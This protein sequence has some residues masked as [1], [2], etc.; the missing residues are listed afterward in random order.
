MHSVVTSRFCFSLFVALA[1]CGWG[2]ESRAQSHATLP[3]E[4]KSLREILR[5]EQASPQTLATAR[6]TKPG[7]SKLDDPWVTLGRVLFF[8][9]RLSGTNAM[10]CATCHTPGLGWADGQPTPTRAP[11]LDRHTQSLWNVGAY[12]EL[13]WDGRASNLET[14]VD[15]PLESPDEMDGS[16]LKVLLIILRDDGVKQLV[17]DV[18]GM[19]LLQRAAAVLRKS[20]ESRSVYTGSTGRE[21]RRV[22]WQLGAIDRK[23][24]DAAY[25][26]VTRSL[27]EFQKTIVSGPAAFD[28]ATTDL[29]RVPDLAEEPM[30]RGAALFFG[31]AGCVSCHQGPYL[32][33]SRFHPA[34]PIS[35]GRD[36]GL[37]ATLRSGHQQDP[38][39]FVSSRDGRPRFTCVAK[40]VASRRHAMELLK[41]GKAKPAD[42]DGLFKTPSLRDVSTH[43]PY[44]HDGSAISLE[45]AVRSEAKRLSCNDVRK[46][47][48]R[49]SPRA[50]EGA[51]TEK[52]L[53]DITA[54]LMSM[55]SD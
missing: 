7:G 42:F 55:E 54:F 19:D 14:Q 22:Y 3:R 40:S 4:G 53:Q 18:G 23:H 26:V 9:P 52:D 11:K 31:K 45:Q 21:M 28:R 44:F 25:Q 33:D 34:S 37:G 35:S 51:L 30:M 50:S 36:R 46:P 1:L 39:K 41:R 27:A 15:G 2:D 13:F 47:S 8:D 16:R 24:I 49:R 12:H 20:L 6:L 38:A 43:P 10:S 48:A 29:N 32:T 5:H 17:E